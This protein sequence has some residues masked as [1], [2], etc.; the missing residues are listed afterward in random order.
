MPVDEYDTPWKEAIEIYFLEC[1][2]FF[3]PIAAAE[4][5]WKDTIS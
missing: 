1:I 2:E 3:F 5:D 4:I